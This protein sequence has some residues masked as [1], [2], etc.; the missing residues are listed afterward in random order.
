[1]IL[2]EFIVTYP[3]KLLNRFPG[4]CSV[5]HTNREMP[6]PREEDKQGLTRYEMKVSTKAWKYSVPNKFMI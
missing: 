1:M 6:V 3:S 2:S 4:I 5:V